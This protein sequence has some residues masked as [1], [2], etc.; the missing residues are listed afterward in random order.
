MVR[1]VL[2]SVFIG[3]LADAEIGAAAVFIASREPALRIHVHIA[4]MDGSGLVETRRRRIWH[5]RTRDTVGVVVGDDD[6]FGV[7]KFERQGFAALTGLFFRLG[8]VEVPVFVM[9]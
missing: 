7:A 9:I 2:D 1:K 5:A 4:E 8:R 3:I 6:V